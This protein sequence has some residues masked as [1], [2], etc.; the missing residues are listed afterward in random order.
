MR[1]VKIG[2]AGSLTVEAS[3]VVPIVLFCILFILNQGIERYGQTVDTAKKQ[4]M[5]DELDMAG[6]FRKIELLASY[7]E[8][9]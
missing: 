7:I 6:D 5:W 3:F 2:A 1:W 9:E 4:E 8:T